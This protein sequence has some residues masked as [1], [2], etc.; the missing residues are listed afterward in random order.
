[1]FL[2]LREFGGILFHPEESIS[3][4]IL[5]IGPYLVSLVCMPP[6]IDYIFRV[7]KFSL[8]FILILMD[9]L[10]KQFQKHQRQ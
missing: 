8:F 6:F 4:S 2:K 5:C 7:L 10:Q 9:S 3:F 1:M